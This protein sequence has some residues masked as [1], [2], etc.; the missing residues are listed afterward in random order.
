MEPATLM[1]RAAHVLDAKVQAVVE[2]VHET[3]GREET[4]ATMGKSA[5]PSKKDR[6]ASSAAI[7]P[8][9]VI[10]QYVLHIIHANRA[11]RR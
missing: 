8:P 6:K 9:E 7:L 5:G 10:E 3:S 1:A 2:E 4:V 11:C